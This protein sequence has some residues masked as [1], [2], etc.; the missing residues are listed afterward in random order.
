MW[1]YILGI[2]TIGGLGDDPRYHRMRQMAF[3]LA[4]AF[5]KVAVRI[6]KPIAWLSFLLESLGV[7]EDPPRLVA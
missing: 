1:G 3:S 7:S 2:E 4:S 5:V 6:C